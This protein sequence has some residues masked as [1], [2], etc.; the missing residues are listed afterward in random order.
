MSSGPTA[1]HDVYNS[2]L[3]PDGA[4]FMA[5]YNEEVIFLANKGGGFHPNYLMLG[6]N[7]VTIESVII[8]GDT[9]IW[10]DVSVVLV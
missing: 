9:V 3:N 4:N 1:V 6:V 10:N 2:R 8:V 5:L 7:K